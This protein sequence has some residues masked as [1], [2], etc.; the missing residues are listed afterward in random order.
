M[1]WLVK[2]NGPNDTSDGQ[3]NFVDCHLIAFFQ[4]LEI[5]PNGITLAMDYHRRSTGEA[6]MHSR[7]C[8]GET[9]GKN[10]HKEIKGCYD[11]PRSLLGQQPGPHDRPIGGR[12]NYYAAGHGKD[13]RYDGDY[14]GFDDYGGHSDY[15]Y[16]NDGFD[17][18]VS[19]G[20]G[21]GGHG[22][23]G[24]GDAS[25]DFHGSHFVHMRETDLCAYE[26]LISNKDHW[27]K[28]D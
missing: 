8:T 26:N 25:S 1:D 15:G 6:F 4:G 28:L 7:K 9:Q 18:S 5:V 12:G 16:R 19:D 21:M 20:R 13:D 23:G 24:R 3:N 17:D 14:G 11:P 22:Y 10:E 2:H 27:R